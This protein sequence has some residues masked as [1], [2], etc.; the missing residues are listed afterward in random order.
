[1]TE[2][3]VGLGAEKLRREQQ[4]ADLHQNLL[5]LL[6]E[7]EATSELLSM[8]ILGVIETVKQDYYVHAFWVDEE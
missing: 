1:M 7:P 2:K 8:D 5:A 4:A 3:V 6:Y